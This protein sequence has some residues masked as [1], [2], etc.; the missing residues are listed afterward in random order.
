[1]GMARKEIWA[2][3]MLKEAISVQF[4][5]ILH[6][7]N[8]IN[9]K[10]LARILDIPHDKRPQILS[11]FSTYDIRNGIYDMEQLRHKPDGVLVE[12]A[13]DTI[14]AND[15]KIRFVDLVGHAPEE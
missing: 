15:R 14:C 1:M 5:D 9:N 11:F 6:D 7:V 10:I 13:A 3:K 12:Q 2:L 4:N 8:S